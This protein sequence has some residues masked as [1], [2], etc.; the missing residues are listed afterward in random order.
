MSFVIKKATKEQ[1][2]LRLALIGLAGSG[3]TYSALAIATALVPG[4]RVCVIDTERGS[5]SLYADRFSF[6]VIELE[7]HAPE[8][9]VEAIEHVEANGYDVCVIDS[10]THAWAGKDGALEQVDKAQRRNGSGNS[11]TAWRDVTPKHNALV[12][13][14]LRTRMHLIATMRSKMEYVLELD[15]RTKKQVPRKVGLA[16]I[17]RDGMDYEFTVVGDMDLEHRLIVTKSRCLGAVD[18][19]DVI[20]KPGEKLAAKLRTWLNSGVAPAPRPAPV[21]KKVE[22]PPPQQD[23]SGVAIEGAPAGD[24]LLTEAD[25]VFAEYLLAISEAPDLKSLDRVASGPAKPQ[26]GTRQYDLAGQAYKARKAQIEQLAAD[27]AEKLKQST[28]SEAGAA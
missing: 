18:V 10:L 8:N 21:E 22:A 11:F 24:P 12:E 19:G 1:A 4:G 28:L 6:D 5:A 3:K 16:P 23:V 2:K 17:Q 9:Y 14:M 20:E 15:E 27:L 7:S 25:R 26:K 13:A